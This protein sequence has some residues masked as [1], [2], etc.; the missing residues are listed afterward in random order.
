MLGLLLLAPVLGPGYVLVRDMSF[1]PDPPLTGAL[2]GLDG[3]P[4]AVPSDLLVALP[5]QVLPSGLVQDLVLLT[6]VVT[7]AWG[8]ARLVPA[9]SRSAVVTAAT[10]YGWS[11]C[12]HERLLL[13]QW[14]QLI[15]HAALPWALRAALDWRAGRPGAAAR[16]VAALAAGALGGASPGL[17]VALGVVAV[18]AGRGRPAV[19]RVLLAVAAVTVLALPWLVPSVLS[20]AGAPAADPAGVAAF[21]ARADVPG[22]VLVSVLTGGG[23]WAPAAVPPGRAAG[24]PVALALLAL[25]AAGLPLLRRRLGTA[26]AN[27]LLLAGAVG[28][29]LALAGRVP[30]L[31]GVLSWLVVEVPGGGL[32][33]DGAKWLPLWSVLV[34]CAAGCGVD[35]VRSRLPPGAARIAIGVLAAVAPVAALAGAAW[36]EGGALR[37][38][39]YPQAWSRLRVEVAA[40]PGPGPVVVLPWDGPF[41]AYPFTGDRTVLDPA[42]RLA[43]RRAVLDDDLPL[44]T[45]T[46]QGEDADADVVDA[47]VAAG[48]PLLP[49]LEQI[50]ASGVLLERTAR[51][52]D[53]ERAAGQVVGLRL[54][55]D[56]PELALWEVPGGRRRAQ[57]PLLPVLLGL[58]CP[59]GL[60]GWCAALSVLRPR[61]PQAQRPAS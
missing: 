21:A 45:G 38:S 8:A 2:L 13:G 10:A 24:L 59:V 28:L 7:A 34:A 35:T 40:L 26:G 3:V 31:R 30:G 41:R 18:L 16:T 61:G 14:A 51:G 32:L 43:G 23:I 9:S 58:A 1:V 5:A 6:I 39:T 44:T 33:R 12:L 37:S 54:V 57:V 53:P 48:G 11:V 47:A 56:D 22:G 19:R 20:P 17:L 27:G 46:V 36:G 4:R 50:G 55:W 49:A 42:L 29:V 25:A 15:G 52:A 60:G